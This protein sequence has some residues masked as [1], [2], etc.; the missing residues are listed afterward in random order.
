LLAGVVAHY[1]WLTCGQLVYMTVPTTMSI[2][3]EISFKIGRAAW[4]KD[5]MGKARPF[6]LEPS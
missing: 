1:R 5:A 4:F 3:A 2:P 6:L